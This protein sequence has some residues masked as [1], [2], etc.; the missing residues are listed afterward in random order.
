MADITQHD[1]T[2]NLIALLKETFEGPSPDSGSRSE[3]GIR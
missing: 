3:I 1:F 2:K